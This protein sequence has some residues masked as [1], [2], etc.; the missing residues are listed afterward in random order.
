MKDS[1]ICVFITTYNRQKELKKL[2]DDIFSNQIQKIQIFVFDDN[3]EETYD[4]SNYS[5][6]YLKFIENHGKKKFWKII[7]QIFKL[8]KNIES[9]YYFFLQDDQRIPNN[10][11]EKAIEI[12]ENI[13]DEKKISLELRTDNRTERSNWTKFDPIDL[14]DYIRTQWV[15]LDFV[16]KYNFFQKL[17]FELKPIEEKRWE[18]DPNLST[19]V[20]H[21]ISIRLNDQGLSMFHVKK[22]LISHGD[23]E[24]KLF[25]ELRKKEKLIAKI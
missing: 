3:S 19:G 4:L 6:K 8:C 15:E 12:F 9:D 2:L 23:V 7:N 17:N 14:G 18:K 16:C 22:S 20:G 1:K 5:V 25:P 21:Q 13:D 11:F 24:S 10:F